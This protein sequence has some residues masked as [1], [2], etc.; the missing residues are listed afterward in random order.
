MPSM[1]APMG[2]SDIR[3][4]PDVRAAMTADTDPMTATRFRRPGRQQLVVLACL[5]A[6]VTLAAACGS[7][8]KVQATPA[9]ASSTGPRISFTSPAN[10]ATVKSPV[11]VAMTAS[12]LT[13][14]SAG[15][16][17]EGAGHFHVMIDVACVAAGTAIAKDDSHVHLGKAQLTTE[18]VLAPG[19][20]TLCLQVGDGAHMALAVTDEITVNVSS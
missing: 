14:E 4:M 20:H 11:T 9:S 10:G 12:G 1:L 5:A 6:A 2:L 15:E 8:K 19:P 13:I 17:H 18:L 16:V 7:D 3:Q